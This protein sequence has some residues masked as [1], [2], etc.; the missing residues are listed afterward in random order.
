MLD[1]IW[2]I[3]IFVL[4]SFLPPMHAAQ[5]VAPQADGAC[6]MVCCADGCE[7][8]GCACAVDAPERSELPEEPIAPSPPQRELQRGAAPVFGFVDLVDPGEMTVARAADVDRP[9][10]WGGAIRLEPIFCVWRT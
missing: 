6:A 10:L 7:C 5:S 3:V 2:L 1:R 9:A 8:T 4:G